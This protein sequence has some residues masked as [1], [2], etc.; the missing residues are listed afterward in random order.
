[1]E[2]NKF[3]VGQMVDTKL[4]DWGI[5]TRYL[6]TELVTGYEIDFRGRI[7]YCT[8]PWLT[9]TPFWKY[10][11]RGGKSRKSS[12]FILVIL[13]LMWGVSLLQGH[14]IEMAITT[15]VVGAWYVFGSWAQYRKR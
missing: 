8:E 5:V 14:W 10:M 11:L 7:G 4:G 12:L 9:T 1:M 2:E 3:K 15:V 13:A 6:D